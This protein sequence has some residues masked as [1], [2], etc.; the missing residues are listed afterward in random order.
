M[1]Q[2][3]NTLQFTQGAG[4]LDITAPANANLAPPGHY[5]MFVVNSAGVPSVGA[6][7]QFGSAAPAAAGS[8]TWLAR[9]RQRDGR[10]PGL[11]AHRQW[12]QLRFGG[13]SALEWHRPHT[14]FVSA[15]QLSAAIAAAD[16]AAGVPPRSR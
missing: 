9:S 14:S 10:R 4:T 12:Q 11:H 8:C 7:V 6:I 3:L 13:G 16:I 2:R 1:N 5:M 15:T